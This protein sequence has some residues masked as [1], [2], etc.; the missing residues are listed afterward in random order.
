MSEDMSDKT[1]RKYV[2]KN[3][4]RMP[5]IMAEKDVRRYVEKMGQKK[6]HKEC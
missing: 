2:R 4:E 3:A 5:E 6:C 1:V